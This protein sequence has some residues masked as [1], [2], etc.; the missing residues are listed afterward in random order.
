MVMSW[1][2]MGN[3]KKKYLGPSG[4]MEIQSKLITSDVVGNSKRWYIDPVS[5]SHQIALL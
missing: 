1:S 3:I 5:D 2:G 4:L